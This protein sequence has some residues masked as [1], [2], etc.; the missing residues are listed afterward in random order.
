MFATKE[1][2]IRGEVTMGIALHTLKM[3]KEVAALQVCQLPI[4]IL[5]ITH[6]VIN[7]IDLLRESWESAQSNGGS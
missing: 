4:S 7:I 2:S 3:V 1:S 6:I 5:Q